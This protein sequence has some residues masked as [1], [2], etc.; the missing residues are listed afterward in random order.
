M[1]TDAGAIP[2]HPPLVDLVGN[3]VALIG[4]SGDIGTAM[5]DTLL[6]QGCR[7]IAI[8]RN[9]EALAA[10]AHAMAERNGASAALTTATV[11]VTDAP[12]MARLF[13]EVVGPIDGLVNAAGI[14][15]KPHEVADLD[16]ET[17]RKVLDVNVT[18]VFLGMKYGVARLRAG[19]AI[20][21][22]A[23]TGGIKGAFGMSAYVA[24]K[25]AVIGLTRSAAIELGPK[26]LRVNA[27][28][29]GPIEGRMIDSIMGSEAEA[30]SPAAQARM[31]VI[32]S[33]RFGRRE[34]VARMVAFLLSDAA[35]F[36]NGGSYMVDGGIYAI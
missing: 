25:H 2:V 7:V 13:A 1:P 27:I 36:C 34:E 12:G 23:S 28:C 3:T 22:F 15:H 17:F 8:D 6:A 31:A 10:L 4:A 5:V 16:V 20:V 30:P 26:G 35:S 9:G 18:G 24:S 32:P 11:D 21:N 29:P 33:R 14:E 19:G